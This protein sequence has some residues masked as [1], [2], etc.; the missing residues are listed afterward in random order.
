MSK[1]GSDK[2]TAAAKR[3]SPAMVGGI[4]SGVTMLTPGDVQHT[5]GPH[6][7][8]TRGEFKAEMGKISRSL[9]SQPWKTSQGKQYSLHVYEGKLAFPDACPVNLEKPSHYE[10]VEVPVVRY[11]RSI[12]TNVSREQANRIATAL[13]C[14]RYWFAIPFSSPHGPDDRA[15]HIEAISSGE[16]GSLGRVFLKNRAYAR[17]FGQL[18]NLEGGKWLAA[19]HLAMRVAGLLGIVASGGVVL[20]MLAVIYADLRGDWGALEPGGMI[21]GLIG[22][23]ALCLSIYLLVK[24]IQGEPL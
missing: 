24:G 19:R 9:H 16:T 23:V 4:F 12:N 1:Q 5:K 3:L 15:I 8:E 22:L 18:N 10:V 11:S 17:Q 7:W 6:F 2:I 14:D 21:A 13:C 20:A